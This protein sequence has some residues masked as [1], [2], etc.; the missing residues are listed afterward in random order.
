ML[1]RAGVPAGAGIDRR[2]GSQAH[3]NHRGIYAEYAAVR[4]FEYQRVGTI[5][6]GKSLAVPAEP[7][8]QA[9]HRMAGFHALAPPR[10]YH[11]RHFE[12]GQR[13]EEGECRLGR[14]A[15]FKLMQPLGWL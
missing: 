11:G 5:G 9:I 14:G 4:L 6:P 1:E 7:F 2:G 8:K 12:R 15:A 13:V 10:S 3:W